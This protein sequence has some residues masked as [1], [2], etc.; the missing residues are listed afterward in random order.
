MLTPAVSNT[1]P[2][3]HMWPVKWSNVTRK[4]K[5]KVKFLKEILNQMAHFSKTLSNNSNY[6]ICAHVA[7]ETI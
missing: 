5:K 3:G 2:A 4:C 6:F 1:R 7:R